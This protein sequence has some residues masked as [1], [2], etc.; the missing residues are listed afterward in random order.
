MAHDLQRSVTR[1]AANMRDLSM[2]DYRWAM[3]HAHDFLSAFALQVASS[4]MFLEDAERVDPNSESA[5]EQL[6]VAA[7]GIRSVAQ[8]RREIMLELNAVAVDSSS[9]SSS[10]RSSAS[11]PDL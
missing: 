7:R 11:D 4:T 1:V 6:M 10:S 5:W 3:V 8:I 9:S 2:R